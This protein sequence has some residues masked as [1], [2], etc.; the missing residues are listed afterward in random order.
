[1]V[2]IYNYYF[3]LLIFLKNEAVKCDSLEFGLKILL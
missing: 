1:M 2:E 3:I